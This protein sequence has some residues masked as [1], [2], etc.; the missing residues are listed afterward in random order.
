[1][2]ME[3]NVLNKPYLDLDQIFSYHSPF[4]DQADR[5]AKL[6]A[7]AKAYAE[8]VVELTPASAE[9]TLA[10]RD[11]QRASMMANAAISINE[12]NP[13]KNPEFLG[14]AAR[15]RTSETDFVEMTTVPSETIE[16]VFQRDGNNFF[17]FPSP[18]KDVLSK[19]GAFFENSLSIAQY[20][21][22]WEEHRLDGIRLVYRSQRY[23]VTIMGSFQSG[24]NCTVLKAETIDE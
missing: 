10:I 16:A 5:Y 7:A 17:I 11:I 8:L 1:M 12:K 19:S 9:Q 18:A 22:S 15:L 20:N 23:R 4:G 21:P 6:R 13:E 14:F 24:G 3:K 2:S